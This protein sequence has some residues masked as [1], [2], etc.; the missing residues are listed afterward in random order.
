MSPSRTLPTVLQAE[1][2]NHDT[3]KSCYVAIGTRVFDVTDFV[4]GHPGGGELVL[5]YRGKD[6]TEILKDETSHTHSEAA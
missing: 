1:I 2:A 3:A 4:D 6:V 5:E